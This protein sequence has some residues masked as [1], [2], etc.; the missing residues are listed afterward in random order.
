MTL[1]S[2]L[3][4]RHSTREIIAE[5]TLPCWQCKFPQS[6]P[7]S[8]NLDLVFTSVHLISGNPLSLPLLS[9]LH[10]YFFLRLP[11][12]AFL[13]P[14]HTVQA[15]PWSLFPREAFPCSPDPP[16]CSKGCLALFICGCIQTVTLG[17]WN[18]WGI[19]VVCCLFKCLPDLISFGFWNICILF[20]LPF[21]CRD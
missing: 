4:N 8:A 12:R 3:A 6:S 13:V 5:E 14:T 11:S 18:A 7:H 21:C 10:F 15:V 20:W 2:A 17:S 16:T 1:S 19:D 9:H